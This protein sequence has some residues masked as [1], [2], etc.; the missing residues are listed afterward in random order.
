MQKKSEAEGGEEERG[1]WL[2]IHQHSQ[3]ASDQ[4]PKS[5]RH[6]LSLRGAKHRPAQEQRGLRLAEITSCS[7][8]RDLI[9]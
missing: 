3:L 5:G 2:V 9:S 4:P 6:L 1:Q 8:L 7:L